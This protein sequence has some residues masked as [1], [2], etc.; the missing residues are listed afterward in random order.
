MKVTFNDCEST[1]ELDKFIASLSA[2]DTGGNDDTVVA[3]ITPHTGFGRIDKMRRMITISGKAIDLSA[4]LYRTTDV[5]VE[6][7]WSH[8]SGSKTVAKLLVK[9]PVQ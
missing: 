3:T 9:L 6:N 8:R 4:V 5:V 2:T 1:P 7:L